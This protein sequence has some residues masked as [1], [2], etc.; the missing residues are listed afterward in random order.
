MNSTDIISVLRQMATFR[1]LVS[2]RLDMSRPID[3]MSLACNET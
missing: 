2:V 1:I 3:M